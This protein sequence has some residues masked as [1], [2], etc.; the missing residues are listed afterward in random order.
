MAAV[1]VAVLDAEA[2]LHPAPPAGGDLGGEI[3][4]DGVDAGV[5][6]GDGHPGPRGAQGPRGPGPDARE[7]PQPWLEVLGQGVPAHVALGVAD[8]RVAVQAVQRRARL[9]GRDS[10]DLRGG[11]PQPLV[12][13]DV[14]PS[15]RAQALG[16]RGP[17]GVGDDEPHRGFRGPRRAWCAGP[18]D[19]HDSSGE[20]G[21]HHHR[22]AARPGHHGVRHVTAY[23]SCFKESSARWTAA[24][25][26][27]TSRR[28]APKARASERCAARARCA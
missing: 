9:A 13:P 10:D 6:D 14:G 23:P 4:V 25:P 24:S 5:D 8:G 17:V 21:A 26:A 28:A 7:V 20:Q 27:P 12:Q 2:V 18:Q 11:Q 15:P 1:P 22:R 3:L 19:E 16:R